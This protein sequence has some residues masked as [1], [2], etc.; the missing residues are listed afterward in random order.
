M[1]RLWAIEKVF[2]F[3]CWATLE[4]G[5]MVSFYLYL[6]VLFASGIDTSVLLRL[7]SQHCHFY[8]TI[9]KFYTRLAQ[10][11]LTS[12]LMSSDWWIRCIWSPHFCSIISETMR[13]Y[14]PGP[15]LMP[16]EYSE[17]CSRRLLHPAMHYATGECLGHTQWPQDL[18]RAEE[19]HAR[20][21]WRSS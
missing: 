16:H 10:D 15:L 6:K 5:V 8:W 14:P 2:S 3:F 9:S 13:M 11:W 12:G 20:E 21:I 1:Y 4:T 19:V 7:W 18:D 17:E